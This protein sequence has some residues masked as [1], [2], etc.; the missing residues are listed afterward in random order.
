MRKC[1]NC[2][3]KE[4]EQKEYIVLRVL[5]FFFLPLS[6]SSLKVYPKNGK[7]FSLAGDSLEQNIS[8]WGSK[9]K[10]KRIEGEKKENQNHKFWE[11]KKMNFSKNDSEGK[12][13]RIQLTRNVKFLPQTFSL[14]LSSFLSVFQ[15]VWR[16]TLKKERERESKSREMMAQE[17][18]IWGGRMKKREE[19]DGGWKNV[20]RREVEDGRI[21]SQVR[22]SSSLIL[23]SYSFARIRKNN[24]K[25]KKKKSQKRKRED[26]MKWK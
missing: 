4:V 20:R 16:M 23:N 8:K 26:G 9:R 21:T 17:M 15:F 7:N 12:T 11:R 14:F 1:W 25:E 10:R 3:N 18:I 2:I 6:F 24:E 13:R 19:G 5:L 22:D